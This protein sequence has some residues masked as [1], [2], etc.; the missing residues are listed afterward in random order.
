MLVN[1]TVHLYTLVD[2]DGDERGPFYSF[3]EADR[4]RGADEAIMGYEFE[5]SDSQFLYAPEGSTQWVR[6]GSDGEMVDLHL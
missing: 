2:R 3:P 4:E 5:F 1:G 6:P